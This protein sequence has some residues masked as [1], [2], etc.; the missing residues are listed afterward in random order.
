P[1]VIVWVGDSATRSTSALG[2]ESRNRSVKTRLFKTETW[3]MTTH[4]HRL[5]RHARPLKA[6]PQIP[7]THPGWVSIVSSGSARA[8]SI[9]AL[10]T[11]HGCRGLPHIPSAGVPSG[12]SW[13]VRE[14]P[15]WPAL[16]YR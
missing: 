5:L 6:R 7:S 14:G 10:H 1:P 11:G 13:L 12:S 15:A 4:R 9:I 8:A 2:R 3:G 16:V